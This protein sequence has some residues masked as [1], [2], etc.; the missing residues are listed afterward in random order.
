MNELKF[1]EKEVRKI[2]KGD[3]EI[4][5]FITALLD[6]IQVLQHRSQELER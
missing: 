2:S 6:H 4:A 1:S 3:P 5:S